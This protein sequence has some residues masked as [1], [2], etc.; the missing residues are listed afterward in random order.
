MRPLC[1]PAIALGAAAAFAV[2]ARGV[3]EAAPLAIAGGVVW[4]FFLS[5]IVTL[6]LLAKRTERG[7]R[8]G[9]AGSSMTLA[10]AVWLCTLPFVFLLIVPSRGT[11]A[12]VTTAL[13]LLA[14]IAL[15]CFAICR[16]TR[17]GGGGDAGAGSWT[18]R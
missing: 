11:G 2:V 8:E 3:S 17:A 14:A 6:P 15:A 9:A 5:L 1:A 7:M 10:I 18:G 4:V 16:W 12:A 13:V